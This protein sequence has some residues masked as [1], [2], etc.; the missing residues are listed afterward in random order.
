VLIDFAGE[1]LGDARRTVKHEWII[2][3]TG[4]H[5]RLFDGLEAVEVEVLF[6]LEFVGAM[7]IADGDG[8]RID[9]GEL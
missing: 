6:A 7:R 9:L 5:E 3:E 2:T 1:I 8:E 4:V